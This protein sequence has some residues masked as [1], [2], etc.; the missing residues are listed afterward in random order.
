MISLVELEANGS[1]LYDR[2]AGE[3]ERPRKECE[4]AQ[5]GGRLSLLP[6]GYGV[7]FLYCCDIQ[8]DD[9][10]PA[11]YVNTGKGVR[12]M[13]VRGGEDRGATQSSCSGFLVL[14]LDFV[15]R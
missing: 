1:L 2:F 11:G 12:S 15:W 9:W 4:D 14:A 5:K 7:W 6:R 10:F 13:K 3:F 8:G